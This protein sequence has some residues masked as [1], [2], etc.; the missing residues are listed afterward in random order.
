MPIPD[1]DL[2]RMLKNLQKAFNAAASHYE[3]GVDYYGPTNP[4][5]RQRANDLA[6]ISQAYLEAQREQDQRLADKDRPKLP[7]PPKT[8]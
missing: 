3:I 5:V 7:K 1:K 8:A 6:T 4:E 2:E